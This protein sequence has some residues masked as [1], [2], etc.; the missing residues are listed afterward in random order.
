MYK[1]TEEGRSKCEEYI[2]GLE[3]RRQ[4]LLDLGADTAD[5]T[6]LP[7]VDAIEGDIGFIGVDEDGEYYNNWAITDENDSEEPIVLCLGE[8]FIETDDND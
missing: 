6:S 1:L 2:R 5:E 3:Q 8:D 7:T 4:E